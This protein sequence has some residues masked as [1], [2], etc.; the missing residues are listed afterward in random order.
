MTGAIV[1]AGIVLGIV[2]A[3]AVVVGIRRKEWAVAV[4]GVLGAI[5]AS[6]LV[7][8]PQQIAGLYA[9]DPPRWEGTPT[10][11]ALAYPDTEQQTPNTTSL[12][13]TLEVTFLT[14]AGEYMTATYPNTAVDRDCEDRLRIGWGVFLSDL[15]TH[16]GPPQE[17]R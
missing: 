8:S 5:I 6:T 13:R 2:G 1:A 15:D 11:V 3:A 4:A 10:I 9:A 16:C 14:R 7:T 17:I 12:G